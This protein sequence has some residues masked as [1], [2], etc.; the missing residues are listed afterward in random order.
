MSATAGAVLANFQTR[1]EAIA[2]TDSSPGRRFIWVDDDRLSADQSAGMTRSFN[3]KWLGREVEG[4][5]D[6]G[7]QYAEHGFLVSVAYSRQY[8]L[9]KRQQI[10]LSDSFDIIKALRDPRHFITDCDTRA[11]ARDEQADLGQNIFLRQTW[12]CVIREVE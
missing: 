3:V 2:P 1:I 6:M 8:E 4:V 7:Q 10:M 11:L 12:R 9:L 5:E